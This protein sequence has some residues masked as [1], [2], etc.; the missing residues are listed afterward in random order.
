MDKPN[1]YQRCPSP[2][3]QL[4][5]PKAPCRSWW[6]CHE[7]DPQGSSE[8][9]LKH[10]KLKA[11]KAWLRGWPITHEEHHAQMFFSMKEKCSQGTYHLGLMV[12]RRCLTTA[13]TNHRIWPALDAHSIILAFHSVIMQSL[14]HGSPSSWLQVISH[15][16]NPMIL[17][18]LT[19]QCFN[20]SIIWSCYQSLNHCYQSMHF[21]DRSIFCFTRTSWT[22][23][24]Q[25][26]TGSRVEDVT[27]QMEWV[28]SCRY[29]T[30]KFGIWCWWKKTSESEFVYPI[31]IYICLCVSIKPWLC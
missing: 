10:P 26:V 14:N 29:K 12:D 24:R 27:S 2:V 28:S 30:G 23:W 9:A 8:S 21:N 20:D 1:C 31:L 13:S 18:S 16:F 6:D 22:A 3:H 11:W 7:W 17:Q 15:S 19:I 4:V 25:V 5:E